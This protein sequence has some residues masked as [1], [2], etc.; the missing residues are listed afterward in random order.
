MQQMANAPH[1]D[2]SDSPPFKNIIIGGP[3]ARSSILN[4]LQKT[5]ELAEHTTLVSAPSWVK[6][7][8]PDWHEQKWGQP[9]R[10]LT[11]DT[12]EIA[13]KLY[14]HHPDDKL[15]TFEM[16]QEI[17]AK[18]RERVLE[19]GIYLIEDEIECIE[20]TEEGL[21]AHGEGRRQILA[22]PDFNFHILH[23]GLKPTAP[24]G[25][26]LNHFGKVYSFAKTNDPDPVVVFG[27][28]LSLSWACRDLKETPIIHVIPPGD[29][30]RPD[31][32]HSLHASILLEESEI[33]EL[34]DG[35]LLFKGTDV[36]N[37]NKK[38]QIRVQKS[39]VYSAMGST[40]NRELIRVND[41]RNVTYLDL[42]SI[43]NHGVRTFF[44]RRHPEGQRKSTGLGGTIVPPGSFLVN[45]LRIEHALGTYNLTQPNAVVLISA[46]EAA[47]RCK[48]N[49][50]G[51]SISPNFF[52]TIEDRTRHIFQ[53]SIPSE[54][55][56]WL[57]IKNAFNKGVFD[58]VSEEIK[59][60]AIDKHGSAVNWETFKGI[61]TQPTEEIM[62]AAHITNKK[63][64]EGTSFNI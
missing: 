4:M 31:L 12:R 24:T 58:R 44:G 19:S 17:L 40:L 53:T 23:A 13:T 18:Q 47:V 27:G 54:E 20:Q 51:I 50:A 22:T 38:I 15:M 46:W 45:S 16:M 3:A 7:V 33:E 55:H 25:I 32:K 61:I 56:I 59:P 6:Y 63:S 57:V 34:P 48:L 14:P 60:M 62:E 29:R 21:V 1:N 30:A 39:Q 10:Y 28:G 5:P 52:S 42:S 9:P 8:H 35:T 64:E 36:F 43:P 26:P 37:E 41:S 2:R 11:P 49:T